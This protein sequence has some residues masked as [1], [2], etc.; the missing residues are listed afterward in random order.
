MS[1]LLLNSMEML[2][3]D[4][5]PGESS[6]LL[7]NME[8]LKPIDVQDDGE[9]HLSPA[10]MS[11]LYGQPIIHA[12]QFRPRTGS[13][14]RERPQPF[15]KPLCSAQ[16][17]QRGVH[18]G[19]GHSSLRYRSPQP[20]PSQ[21]RTLQRQTPDKRMLS[22]LEILESA[23]LASKAMTKDVEANKT[24][25]RLS[26]QTIDS[27]PKSCPQLVQYLWDMMEA[28]DIANAKAQDQ[29]QQNMETVYAKA[30]TDF[31]ERYERDMKAE[32]ANVWVATQEQYQQ[33]L[34]AVEVI[35]KSKSQTLKQY[36]QLLMAEESQIS[37]KAQEKYRQD[38]QTADA[39][40]LA[41]AQDSYN[42]DVKSGDAKIKVNVREQYARDMNAADVKAFDRKLDHIEGE[43]M[44]PRHCIDLDVDDLALLDLLEH[45]FHMKTKAQGS[46]A[47]VEH[48]NT[49][50]YDYLELLMQKA[51]SKSKEVESN[52]HRFHT[53]TKA[54]GSKAKVEHQDTQL[55]DY[56]KLVMQKA[57]SKGKEA[58]RKSEIENQELE[59][60]N[61]EPNAEETE[62]LL[63]YPSSNY[64][65][66]S[67]GKQ[68]EGIAKPHQCGDSDLQY[69]L[70]LFEQVGNDVKAE[71]DKGKALAKTAE[72]KFKANKSMQPSVEDE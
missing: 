54:Q 53:K 20:Q 52:Q 68:L 34:K 58:A 56:L 61:T 32:R 6:P 69:Y 12:K 63:N 35:V 31:Q 47:K 13:Y 9:I 46:K 4:M 59:L 62:H 8:L 3:A 2:A 70:N 42:Q 44:Y 38:V 49:Q 30:E 23:T 67:K 11:M 29:Y 39:K 18:N 66:I 51:D 45:R 7:N 55:C 60:A 5:E 25:Q 40:V 65:T 43:A 36:L 48:Q 1:S 17:H 14:V 21:Q 28:D 16:Q 26:H 22:E 15:E 72:T 24:T 71:G 57:D 33:N 50:L 19:F 37:A 41:N 64:S 10:E 27:G